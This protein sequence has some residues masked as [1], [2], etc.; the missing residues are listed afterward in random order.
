MTP[1]TENPN[2]ANASARGLSWITSGLGWRM[3]AWLAK[4][5]EARWAAGNAL[6][7]VIGVNEAEPRLIADSQTY[8][9]ESPDK[10]LKQNSH[11]RGAGIFEDDGRWL[12]LGRGHLQLYQE[13][14]QTLGSR[15]PLRRIVEWGCGGGMNAVHF[16]PL[17]QEFFGV[18]ISSASLEE[19]RKQMYSAGLL[20]N[21]RPVL[22]DAAKPEGAINLIGGHCDLLISTYVF[23][24]L[25]TP[26][27]GLRV[28]KIACELLSPGGTA[29]IQTKYDEGNW[30]T[31]SKRWNYA[32]NLAWNATYRIEEFWQAVEQSGLTPKMVKLLPHQPLVN[33]RNYAYYFLQ[34]SGRDRTA[35]V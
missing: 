14:A 6:R 31:R 5:G 33:D 16:G 20:R 26:E 8:W 21:F 18:D 25:P 1:R 34:K 9:N 7:H 23:E 22:I 32:R 10:S 15:A 11:W 3:R 19:C 13:F 17:A 35:T 12:A 27:Y 30:K 29:M 24:L 28:L 2:D 4:A